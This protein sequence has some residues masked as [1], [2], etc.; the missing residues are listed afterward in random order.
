MVGF[1]GKIFFKVYNKNKLVKWSINIFVISG[2]EPYSGKHTTNMM[3]RQGLGVTS[4]VI[5]HLVKKL[6]EDY[7]SVDRGYRYSRVDSTQI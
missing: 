3:N 2:L 6:E 1:K 7:G 5:L 4:R